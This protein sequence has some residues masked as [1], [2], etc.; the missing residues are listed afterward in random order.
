MRKLIH[1]RNATLDGYI[2]APGDDIGWSVPSGELH[3][4][5]NDR[6][7]DI[8]VSLYGR[9]LWEAMNAHWPAADQHPDATSVEVEFA[10]LRH[11]TP[12]VVFSATLDEVSGNAR[13]VT[14]SEAS[15]DARGRSHLPRSARAPT[16]VLPP[17]QLC[18]WRGGPETQN[19]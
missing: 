19:P 16:C 8:G 4:W 15:L 14:R 11:K 6:A 13:L 12:K 3:Q 10:R 1:S 5:F 9:K 18:L 2:A 7:R 17:R